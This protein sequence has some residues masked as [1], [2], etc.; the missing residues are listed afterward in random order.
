MIRNWNTQYEAY[1]P[2][3]MEGWSGSDKGRVAIDWNS[4]AG[5]ELVRPARHSSNRGGG[6]SGYVVPLSLQDSVTPQQ[7]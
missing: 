6:D 4:S 1:Q 3:H 2:A 7:L 5:W